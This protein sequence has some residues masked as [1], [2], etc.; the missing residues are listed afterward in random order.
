MYFNCILSFENV[1]FLFSREQ[2][3]CFLIPSSH[4]PEQSVN[5]EF[6]LKHP[7]LK[8]WNSHNFLPK[9]SFQCGPSSISKSSGGFSL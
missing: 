5:A 2:K 7:A 9:Q 1:K 4:C 6:N 3:P 8:T